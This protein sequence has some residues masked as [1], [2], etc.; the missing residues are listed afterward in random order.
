MPPWLADLLVQITVFFAGCACCG[1]D[2]K[3][4]APPQPM[5]TNERSQRREREAYPLIPL[6]RQIEGST[7]ED[8]DVVEAQE[9]DL[10]GIHARA[11]RLR[12]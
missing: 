9:A 3:P 7:D 6:A 12:Y 8:W 4:P 2:R 11:G 5:L 1:G 10:F